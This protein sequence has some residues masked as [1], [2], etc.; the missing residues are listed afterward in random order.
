MSDIFND[1][2]PHP[3]R[4]DGAF[5]CRLCPD[6]FPRED[7][8]WCGCAGGI[9][10]DDCCRAIMMG[11][12]RMLEAISKRRGRRMRSED[13]VSTCMECERLVRLVTERAVDGDIAVR[14]PLH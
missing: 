1:D 2:M 11:E 14:L 10:C 5:R 6:T 8:E 13:V 9:V 7:N 3:E 12:Q 4:T